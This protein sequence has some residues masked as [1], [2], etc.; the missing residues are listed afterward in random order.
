MLRLA[1]DASD[2]AYAAFLPDGQFTKVMCAPFSPG[3]VDRMTRGIFSSTERE[4]GTL[5]HALEWLQ[6]R[7]AQNI[8]QPLQ[9]PIVK[10][11]WKAFMPQHAAQK[12]A[13]T[14]LIPL[15]Y[16]DVSRTRITGYTRTGLR[17][18]R[19]RCAS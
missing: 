17:F 2:K 15:T 19:G 11:H 6:Q 5:R 1:G 13:T 8:R 10:S 14:I 3:E 7:V 9:E 18:R 12:Q 16:V 4:L